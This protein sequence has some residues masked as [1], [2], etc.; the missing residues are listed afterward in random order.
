MIV[1]QVDEAY[2]TPSRPPFGRNQLSHEHEEL[3]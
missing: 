3:W 1:E 2:S